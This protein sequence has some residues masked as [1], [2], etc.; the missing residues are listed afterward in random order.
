MAVS[1]WTV[2]HD[3]M[4]ATGLSPPYTPSDGVALEVKVVDNRRFHSM[5]DGRSCRTN[6]ACVKWVPYV[7]PQI[8]N[9]RLT[10]DPVDWRKQDRV[11]DKNGNGA[12]PNSLKSRNS[13]H[14]LKPKQLTK[15]D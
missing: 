14:R 12:K 9:R 10:C 4:I 1:I 11:F 3:C 7:L 13:I 5:A 8:R 2:A 6:Q 15:L